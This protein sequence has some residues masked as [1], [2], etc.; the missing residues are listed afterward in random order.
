[1]FAFSL[2]VLSLIIMDTTGK[3][4]AAGGPKVTKAETFRAIGLSD[5]NNNRRENP[6]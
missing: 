3:R 6:N 4:R 2:S 5:W 1:M